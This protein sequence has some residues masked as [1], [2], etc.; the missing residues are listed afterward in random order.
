MTAPASG[1][2]ASGIGHRTYAAIVE[3]EADLIGHVAYALYKRDKLKF[4][5]QE[6]ARTKLPV[7]VQAMDVF[8]RGCNLDTRI[9]SYRLEAERLLEQMTEYVLEDA[10]E[11]LERDYQARLVRELSASKPWSRAILESLVGSV[12]IALVWAMIVVV[13]STSRVGFDQVLGDVLNKDITDRP[14]QAAPLP[15]PP[16]PPPTR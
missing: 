14:T 12:A 16:S 4:C 11:K 5:E 6:Y 9:A 1:E 15:L 2:A 3:D 10:I 13:I 7:T 8:I